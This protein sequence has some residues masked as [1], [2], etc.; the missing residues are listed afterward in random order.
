MH[1]RL[2]HITSLLFAGALA[3][4]QQTNPAGKPEASPRPAETGNAESAAHWR[5]RAELLTAQI[6]EDEQRLGAWMAPVLRAR[7]CSV[8]TK[9][10]AKRA[11]QWC[12]EALSSVTR[13]SMNE[14]DEQRERR[15]R[16][17]T[18]VLKVELPIYLP[19]KAA[20][21]ELLEQIKSW[22]N[23][24][25]PEIRSWTLRSMGV[26]AF[27]LAADDPQQAAELV[28]ST[29]AAGNVFNA[30]TAL[31]RL[32]SRYPQLGE[33]LMLEAV[34]AV[35]ADRDDPNNLTWLTQR[36]GRA[37]G[38]LT[39]PP[40]VESALLQTLAAVTL[41]VSDDPKRV[42]YRC[43][44]SWE[45]A[46][47]L[48]SFPPSQAGQIRAAIEQCKNSVPSD[49]LLKSSLREG[50]S[51]LKT[52]DDYLTAASLS[53][54]VAVR[55]RFKV[56]AAG[57]TVGESPDRALEIIDSLRNSYAI[58]VL[59]QAVRRHDFARV[60]EVVE[61]S[62]KGAKAGLLLMAAQL[63]ARSRDPDSARMLLRE[64][65]KALETGPA[66]RYDTY[67][68][69][70]QLTARISAPDLP[71]ALRQFVA[72]INERDATWP[73][74]NPQ[75]NQGYAP[76]FGFELEPFEISDALLAVGEA[77]LRA[78]TESLV[79]AGQ[80]ETFRLSLLKV[81]LSRY[82]AELS[83]SLRSSPSKANVASPA[84]RQH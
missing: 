76:P 59:G 65:R 83:K 81:T 67:V 34:A 22:Q 51:Q 23:H 28:R 3:L 70:V 40:A 41:D 18:T 9:T 37:D 13:A 1:K 43:T 64:A 75:P 78:D 46:R 84:I 31:D 5:E 12:A 30:M 14:S 80:R 55:A 11:A 77:E 56:T 82:G 4:S 71:F 24:A 36:I 6:L 62:P 29:L 49:T 47:L 44:V 73:P 25:A 54:D 19:A 21:A 2:G 39:L 66:D 63:M 10:D 74:K 72:G 48:A 16:A 17:A 26:A 38:G 27:E 79:R 50:E 33:Q 52:A 8:W 61:R 60:F 57:L 35:N 42:R 20:A 15:L 7:L 58:G 68:G 53:D 69:M 45:A 32:S